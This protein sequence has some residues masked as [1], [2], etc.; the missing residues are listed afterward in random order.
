MNAA[1]AQTP[2]IK[3]TLRSARARLAHLESARRDAE[4]LLA[5]TLN[6][7]LEEFHARPERELSVSSTADFHALIERRAEGYPVAYLTG[8]RGFWSLEYRVNSH[9]LIPRPETETLVEAVLKRVSTDAARDI[10]DLGTGSG[11][12]ALALAGERPACR[13]TAADISRKALAVARQNAAEARLDNIDFI[14]SD[15]FSRLAQQRFHVIVSNPPYVESNHIGFTSGEIRFEPRLALDGG[16]AGLD[17]IRRIIPAVR[18]HLHPGGYLILE[19]G[20]RQGEDVRSL[21]L[22]ARYTRPCTLQDLGGLDR[23][24]LAR[25]L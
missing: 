25:A 22:A 6:C 12:I 13:I 1:P 5:A 24:T 7:R 8:R 4:I 19:H 9:T 3:Q 23:V 10:L 2:T 18:R 21:L 15:W 14:E 17:A 16:P 11:A 20:Y